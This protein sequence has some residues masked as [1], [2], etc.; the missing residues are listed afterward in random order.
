MDTFQ[1]DGADIE[2]YVRMKLVTLTPTADAFE[3]FVPQIW[4]REGYTVPDE[5]ASEIDKEVGSFLQ[6]PARDALGVVDDDTYF[7][8][9]EYHHQRLTDVAQHLAQSR[10]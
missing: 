6:N 8:L 9:L 10:P 7:E 1:I 4:P 2:G 3:L 5:I